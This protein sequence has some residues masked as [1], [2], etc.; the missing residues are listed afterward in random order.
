MERAQMQQHQ[1]TT[2]AEE[3]DMRAIKAEA[4][5]RFGNLSGVQGF[6]V[7]DHTLRIYVSNSGLRNKLP[8]RFHG[9]P[10][11]VVVTGE[12]VAR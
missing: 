5:T 6:G 1:P 2:N 10:I 9:V 12:I 11:D 4:K 3:P 7:G 8:T